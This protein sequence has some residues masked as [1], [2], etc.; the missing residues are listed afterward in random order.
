[1]AVASGAKKVINPGSMPLPRGLEAIQDKDVHFRWIHKD[2][3]HNINER[4]HYGYQ[5]A[6]TSKFKVLEKD[7]RKQPDGTILHGDAILAFCAYKEYKKRAIEQNQWTG[8]QLRAIRRGYH[9]T[10][11]REGRGLVTSFEQDRPGPPTS[12]QS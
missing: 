2:A 3:R 6:T 9:N 8:K 12:T 11:K 4:F 10:T 5:L 1:M 7:P